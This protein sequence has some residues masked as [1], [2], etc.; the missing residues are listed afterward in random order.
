MEISRV[1]S[2]S[3][4]SINFWAHYDFFNNSQPEGIKTADTDCDVIYDPTTRTLGQWISPYNTLLYKRSADSADLKC[5][6]NFQVRMPAPSVRT[7]QKCFAFAVAQFEFVYADLFLQGNRRSSSRVMLT[8]Y[9]VNMKSVTHPCA[10]RLI[11]RDFKNDLTI[12]D[13]NA[14]RLKATGNYTSTRGKGYLC[15]LQFQVEFNTIMKTFKF[16][17][18]YGTFYF[19]DGKC[20]FTRPSTFVD[21][22]FVGRTSHRCATFHFTLFQIQLA[23]VQRPIR[24]HSPIVYLRI[25]PP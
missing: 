19:Q 1:G 7:F 21:A 4:S 17:Y 16:N 18:T 10:D 11:F 9:S 8:L 24:F 22:Q 5:R 12:L 2:Y 20:L 13:V 25:S 6:Y 23:R 14:N 15:Q 3:G